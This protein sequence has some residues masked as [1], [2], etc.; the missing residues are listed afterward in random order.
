M[1]HTRRTSRPQVFLS[2]AGND[3]EKAKRLHDDLV[4]RGMDTFVDERNVAIGDNFVLAVNQRITQSDYFVLLWSQYSVDRPWVEAEWSSAFARELRER[5]S[6]FFVVRLDATP[7]PILLTPRRYLDA[8]S[9]WD[10]MV[11]ELVSTWHRD[12][13]VGEPVLPAPHSTILSTHSTQRPTLFLY[14]RNRA[15]SVAH[16]VAVPED[17]TGQHLEN[18]VRD[19]LALPDIETS[20]KGTV[21]IRFY[22]QLKK[23]GTVIPVDGTKLPELHIADGSIID[24]EVQVEP[25]GPEGASPA[26]TYRKGS[27]MRLSP[28]TTRSLISSAFGHLIPLDTT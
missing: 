25:F 3:R 11:V 22:Y 2:F 14:V 9:N 28:T 17:S 23:S 5:R 13:A 7:L 26:I 1:R 6:F 27:L 8:F 15:L 10:G 20:F 12:R 16:L 19:A 4:D 24:L 18:L 21:G